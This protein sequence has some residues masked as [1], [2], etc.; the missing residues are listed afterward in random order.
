MLSKTE[1]NCFKENVSNLIHFCFKNQNDFA[2]GHY[3]FEIY[4]ALLHNF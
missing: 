4:K 2:T 1:F 3:G